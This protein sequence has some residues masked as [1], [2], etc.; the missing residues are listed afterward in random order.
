MV[1]PYMAAEPEQLIVEEGRRGQIKKKGGGLM[2]M[3]PKGP[4][5]KRK[6]Q[7]KKQDKDESR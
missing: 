5:W 7:G 6:S 1:V 3:R 2:R 4:H